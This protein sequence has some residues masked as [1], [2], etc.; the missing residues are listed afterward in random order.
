MNPRMLL[1]IAP[2]AAM[3]LGHGQLASILA[4]AHHAANAL[5]LGR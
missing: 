2:M 3:A 4:T 5:G 1:W